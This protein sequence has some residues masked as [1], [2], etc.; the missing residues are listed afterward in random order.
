MVTTNGASRVEH[1]DADSVDV[2]EG[3][4]ILRA[5]RV[6]VGIYA[7]GQWHS[8]IEEKAAAGPDRRGRRAAAI[9]DVRV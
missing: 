7:P 2:E 9:P 8:V 3:H 5:H 6:I 1:P 4:L